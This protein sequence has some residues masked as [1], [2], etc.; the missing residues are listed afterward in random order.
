MRELGRPV[1]RRWFIAKA[2]ELFKVIYPHLVTE[3]RG[4]TS[5][6]GFKFSRA[7][8][9]GF[10]RRQHISLRKRTNQAQNQ[11][12]AYRLAVQSFHQFI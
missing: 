4:G 5:Y 11:P 12:E 9:R 7:W 10:L 8:F 1:T 3:S 6:G 2:K